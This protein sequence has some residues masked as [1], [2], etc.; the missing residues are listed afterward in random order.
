MGPA[1][2]YISADSHLEVAVDRWT[3]R[4]PKKYRDRAPRMVELDTGGQA[5]AIEG[6]PLRIQGLDLFGGKT[7]KE[8]SPINGRYEQTEGTGSAEQRLLEQDRDNIEAEVFFPGV[9][10]PTFWRGISND[11]AYKS[12]I[13]AYNEF[14]IEEY[15][16]VN[17]NRLI[18]MGL[19]PE[20]NVD[21]AVAELAYCAKAGMKGVVL[22]SFPS[23]EPFPVPSD[24]KFWEAAV[25]SDLTITAH[26]TLNDPSYTG[27]F[28]KYNWNVEMGFGRDPVKSI[29][30]YYQ[31]GGMSL[32]QLVMAGVFERFP[33]LSIG[34]LEN[35]VGWIPHWLDTVDDEYR[36]QVSWIEAQAGLTLLPRKPSDIILDHNWW[37]F[38]YNPSGVKM[39]HMIGVDKIL[40]SSDFPHYHG[41]WPH[42][43][44]IV[45]EQFSGVDEEEK[46]QIVR[47]NA[48]ERYGIET[49]GPKTYQ[50]LGASTQK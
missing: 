50:E 13:R 22:H 49:E 47:G 30:R 23:R 21:D 17:P 19:I 42:S 45:E 24:D 33:D 34:W 29:G 5:W 7:Y 3:P 31:A 32:L 15:C 35:Q 11:E 36:R 4:M 10:G 40:W 25:D 16:A 46:F 14:L 26:T 27:P 38:I 6:R 18:P 48:L 12:L 28:F 20:T 43:V 37:G 44:E 9:G 8:I 1:Y 2:R 39:R 41:D